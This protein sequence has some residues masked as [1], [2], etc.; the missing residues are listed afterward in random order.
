MAYLALLFS[1]L[2]AAVGALGLASPPRLLGF[3]R[4]FES[5]AGLYAAAG[6]RILMGLALLLAASGS[7]APTAVAVLGIVIL[8]AGI[9]TPLVGL[10]RFRNLLAWW[11]GRSPGFMRA[12]AGVAL[13][14]GLWLAYA[15][16]P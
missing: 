14:F 13:A 15:V 4:R 8:G 16:F 5:P 11:A 10:E 3:V 6:F 2:V 7:R 12:W 1:L 9:A